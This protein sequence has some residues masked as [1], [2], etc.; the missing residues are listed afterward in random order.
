LSPTGFLLSSGTTF[1][2]APTISETMSPSWGSFLAAGVDNALITAQPASAISEAG[3]LIVVRTALA[4]A[5]RR[6]E[7]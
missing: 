5:L 2:A 3:T 7:K 1:V 6:T 4:G